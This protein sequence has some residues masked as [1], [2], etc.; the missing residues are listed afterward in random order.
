MVTQINGQKKKI[1]TYMEHETY[2]A[3]KLCGVRMSAQEVH[4]ASKSNMLPTCSK[5][6]PI[7]IEKIRV[8]GELLQKSNI[9]F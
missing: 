1:K 6:L 3:C 5:C 4:T 8:L 2:V 7:V 9:K